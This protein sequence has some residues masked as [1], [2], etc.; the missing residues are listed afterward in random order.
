[1]RHTGYRQPAFLGIPGS[2]TRFK[3]I[4][5]N[6]NWI[7]TLMSQLTILAPIS[8][9][10]WPLERIPDPVF[11]QKMVGDGLSIDPTDA[12]LVA[13][14]DGEVVS[15]HAAGH[16]VTLRT[17]DGLEVLMHVGLDTVGLKGEG[18]RPRVK[19]G[20]RVRAV[21]R[22]ESQVSKTA[23]SAAGIA[24]VV[25]VG[26]GTYHLLAGLN[27]DQYAAEMRGQLAGPVT[28]G[29]PGARGAAA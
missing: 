4:P 10:V 25:R 8:G 1:M 7:P 23:L 28:G 18:F 9:Q 16:A 29:V 19:P 22:T 14:C 3:L 2:H 11:A 17:Q 20:D 21:V 27:A 12:L 26:G 5:L 15:L 24:A 6:Q 13:C